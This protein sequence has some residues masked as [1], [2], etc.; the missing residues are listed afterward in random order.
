MEINNLIQ[1]NDMYLLINIQFP[2]LVG[3]AVYVFLK[4]IKST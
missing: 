4:K 3:R 2:C 1:I